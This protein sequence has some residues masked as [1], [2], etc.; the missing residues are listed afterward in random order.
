MNRIVT[1]LF[2]ALVL[3]GCKNKKSKTTQPAANFFVSDY[4]K[5]QIAKLD[6]SLYSF[7]KI[8]TF[9]GHSDTTPIK[10]S[11]VKIFAKDFL[12]LPD[13][14]SDKLRDDYEITHLYDED[15]EAFAFTFTTK[16]NHP[17]KSEHVI[18]EPM[19][20]TEG[21]NDIRSIY[22]SLWQT[23]GDSTIRKNMLWEADKSFQI[24]TSSD[25]AGSAETIKKLKV[26]WN[27]PERQNK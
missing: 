3:L 12:D 9:D 19:P 10:N 15:L 1:G 24:T 8:E 21:K 17:V 6:T 23:K 18:V 5:G 20:N 11:E 27:G 25:V 4:I 7:V 13:I 16:E 26:V 2:F 22:I 14:A